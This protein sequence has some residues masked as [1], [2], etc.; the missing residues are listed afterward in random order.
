M[1]VV[2]GWGGGGGGGTCQHTC[3]PQPAAQH[4]AQPMHLPHER[5]RAHN[6]TAR[7]RS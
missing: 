3:L 7:R 6:N 4:F 1:A 2:A 5:S